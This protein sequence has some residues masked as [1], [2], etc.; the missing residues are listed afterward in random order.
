MACWKTCILIVFHK[1]K[2]PNEYVPV[3]FDTDGTYFDTDGTYLG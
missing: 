3:V 1:G 2:I